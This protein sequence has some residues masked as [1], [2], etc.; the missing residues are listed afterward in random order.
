MR[1][2]ED[3]RDTSKLDEYR[4]II[5]GLSSI[6]VVKPRLSFRLKVAWRSRVTG[7]PGI[8]QPS[9]AS[10]EKR[11]G[12]SQFPKAAV[13]AFL[14]ICFALV[15]FFGLTLFARGSHPGD[16]LYVFKVAR[17]NI[18]MAF[19]G[20]PVATAEKRL[21]LAQERL[22]ELDYFVSKKNLEPEKIEYI[23][24]QYNQN[25]V[26][27]QRVIAQKGT[28]PDG[29]MLASQLE[30]LETQKEGILSRM[31]ATAGPD[32]IMAPAAGARVQVLDPSGS[33]S[34]GD[35]SSNTSGQA[36]SAGIFEFDYTSSDKNKIPEIEATVELDGQ[37]TIVPLFAS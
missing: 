28:A 4:D 27:V 35:G 5:D 20:G 6:P 11:T 17:E 18:S 32:S 3:F 10:R 24:K 34:L 13:V 19:T 33:L 16:T 37:K 36:D 12:L 23:A 26:Q 22:K 7:A 29:K 15:L 21:Q 14:V 30:N 25:K 2:T 9:T 8:R 1:V 31:S